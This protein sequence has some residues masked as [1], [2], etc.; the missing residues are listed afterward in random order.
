MKKKTF[1]LLFFMLLFLTGIGSQIK[2]Q[3][4]FTDL[5]IAVSP[6]ME[7]AKY[8]NV[9][10]TV[11]GTVSGDVTFTGLAA[12]DY[13]VSMTLGVAKG[14]PNIG[15]SDLAIS[16]VV[17]TIDAS[18]NLTG[19]SGDGAT[20]SGT[21][22]EVP[23]RFVVARPGQIS[24][25]IWNLGV[26]LMTSPDE[27]T[28]NGVLNPG[29][30]GLGAQD[31]G[32]FPIVF[33]PQELT[34]TG[35]PSQS[36]CSGNSTSRLRI[37]N[38]RPEA[39]IDYT[40][41]V[42][43]PNEILS[44]GN[45]PSWTGYGNE[46]PSLTITHK[47]LTELP[48]SATVTLHA[49]K[50]YG[51]GKTCELDLDVATF[52]VNPVAKITNTA[53]IQNDLIFCPGTK[54]TQVNFEVFGATEVKITIANAIEA[55]L[56]GNPFRLNDPSG[57]IAI[58]AD[59]LACK[60][61][62]ISVGDD[63]IAVGTLFEKYLAAPR[64]YNLVATPIYKNSDGRSCEG[65]KLSF[66][67]VVPKV[68]DPIYMY[69]T[70]NLLEDIFDEDN[71]LNLS[72]VNQIKP[73]ESIVLCPGALTTLGFHKMNIV[74]TIDAVKYLYELMQ[75]NNGLLEDFVK[76]VVENYETILPMFEGDVDLL[77]VLDLIV[78]AAGSGNYQ[79]ISDALTWDVILQLGLKLP[80]MIPSLVG[81]LDGVEVTIPENN[82]GLESMTDKEYTNDFNVIPFLAKFNVASS[83]PQR[84]TV[85]ARPYMYIRG[86]K[87]Y[88]TTFSYDII[89]NPTPTI[90]AI[91]NELMV[92]PPDRNPDTDGSYPIEIISSG[93]TGLDIYADKDDKGIIKNGLGFPGGKTTIDLVVGTVEIG[94]GI[95]AEISLVE[96]GVYKTLITIPEENLDPLTLSA[97]FVRPTGSCEIGIPS[98]FGVVIPYEMP[99]LHFD[100]VDKVLRY[101]NGDMVN[102]IWLTPYRNGDSPWEVS[103]VRLESSDKVSGPTDTRDS[104]TNIIPRFWA[105]NETD[106]V[107]R[108]EFKYHVKSVL[109]G[110][111]F[112]S[113]GSLIIEVEPYVVEDTRIMINEI[114]DITVC[115][116]DEFADIVFEARYEFPD[117]TDTIKSPITFDEIKFE[118]K[119]FE[120]EDVLG[121]GI[122][123]T[124]VSD[125][126]ETSV[127]FVTAGTTPAKS[128][129]AVYG[130]T[131]RWA[132]GAGKTMYFNIAVGEKPEITYLRT[133]KDAAGTTAETAP[134]YNIGDAI[135]I[136]T[137][138]AALYEWVNKGVNIGLANGKGSSIPTFIASKA[139][140][141]EIEVTPISTVACEGEAKTFFI[142]VNAAPSFGDFTIM[143][144][145]TYCSGDDVE[146]ALPKLAPNTEYQLSYV[147]GVDLG[148]RIRARQG[149]STI[150]E[151]RYEN[152]T[153][154]PT[155]ATYNLV[156]VDT[157][158]GAQSEVITFVVTITPNASIGRI[159]NIEAS[160]GTVIP[161]FTFTGN[162][163]TGSYSW[164][165]KRNS[166]K[167]DN[168]ASRGEGSTFP[169]FTAVNLGTR[170]VTATYVV[171]ATSGECST[172]T[173]EFSIIVY[174]EASIPVTLED[175]VISPCKVSGVYT[176]AT[177]RADNNYIYELSL[178]AGEEVG[179]SIEKRQGQWRI[180]GRLTNATD[181][182][183]TA[184]Y[185]LTAVN[186]ETGVKGASEEFTIV[187]LPEP[188][189]NRPNNIAAIHGTEI[190]AFTFTGNVV[191]GTYSWELRGGRDSDK[192]PN[193]ATRGEGSFFP[194]FV[195]ENF[196]NE[197]I[198]A[199]YDV[200]AQSGE[201]TETT[202]FRITVY[203][204]PSIEGIENFVGCGSF[205]G[206]AITR[207]EDNVR[208]DL[209]FV[210]G[211]DFDLEL[212]RRNNRWSVANNNPSNPFKNTGATILIGTYKVTPYNTVT[213]ATGE[214]SY[215]NVT[216]YP[217]PAV[218]KP[219]D[220]LVVNGT[221]VPS[222]AF[223]GEVE[224]SSYK[225]TLKDGSESIPNLAAD[226]RGSAFPAFVAENFTDEA[227]IA[228]YV[229]TPFN[230]YCDGT[231]VE[232]TITV[233]P[234][235]LVPEILDEIFC[236]NHEYEYI[237]QGVYDNTEFTID[238]VSGH[239]FD[240]TI[241]L[242]EEQGWTITVAG[243]E[244][245]LV[246][247]RNVTVTGTYRVTAIN[248]ITAA[249]GDTEEFTITV[250][251]DA[252][253]NTV[254]NISVI[255]GTSVPAFTFTGNAKD[256][257]Y[258]WALKEGSIK[259][260]NLASQG[261][262][263][264][265]PSFV[266]ENFTAGTIA[267]TYVVTATSGEGCTPATKEFTITIY[268]APSIAGIN[269]VVACAQF[270]GFELPAPAA[271]DE[272]VLEFVSGTN[273]SLTLVDGVKVT[274]TY[275]NTTSK[276]VSAIYKVTPRHKETLA[277]GAPN[278]FTI[279]LNPVPTM[280]EPN[281]IRVVTGTSVPEFAFKGNVAGMTYE[282]TLKAES[283]S[284]PNLSTIGEGL[285]FPAFVAEN[286]TDETIVATYVV[287][288]VFEGCEGTPVEFTIT[289][290]PGPQVQEIYDQT[291]CNGSEY[292]KVLD[293]MENVRYE[294][295]YVKGA[296]LGLVLEGREISGS[297]V[298]DTKAPIS[299]TYRITA[300][301][302]ITGAPGDT[303]E[304]TITVLPDLKNEH[305]VISN[306][307]Y[308]NGQ[309]VNDIFF[310]SLIEGARY[311]WKYVSGDKIGT[312]DEGV[313]F[314]SAFVANNT[315]NRTLVATYEVTM[316][317]EGCTSEAKLFTITVYPNN[318]NM[319]N[320]LDVVATVNGVVSLN[321]TVCYDEAF[322][323]IT[324]TA[325]HAFESD[326]IAKG[327]VTF[328]VVL[329][330]GTDIFG[331]VNY[332][333]SED[334][335]IATVSASA[336]PQ[337]EG[338][339]KYEVIA[340]WKNNYSK[341]I[342]ITLT[343]KAAP[344]VNVIADKVYCNNSPLSVDFTGNT[345]D[346]TYTWKVVDAEGNPTA[347]KLG[348]PAGAENARGLS[349]AKLTNNTDGVL[350]DI[351]VVTPSAGGCT[352]EAVVFTISVIPT[353]TVG[354]IAT[355]FVENGANVDAIP[356]T[357][358][359]T[360][361]EWYSSNPTINNDPSAPASGSGSEFPAF[362]AQNVV[363][364]PIISV[365][366]V[367]PVY[368]YNGYTCSGSAMTF[369]IIVAP[370]PAITG[371]ADVIVCDGE[372]V[373]P[374]TPNG[375]PQGYGYYI[376]WTG[377]TSIGLA[378]STGYQKNISGF[379][380][381]LPADADKNNA[382]IVP[383]TV[384][385]K[386]QINGRDY[387]G[388]PVIFNYIVLP[389]AILDANAEAAVA[390]NVE[391]CEGED[392]ELTVTA[393]GYEISYQW[394]KNAIVIPGATE[395]VYSI[396]DA[397]AAASGEYYVVVTTGGS[398]C[399]N[400]VQGQ[401]YTVLVKQDVISQ[402]WNDVL[403]LD[404]DPVTN[405]GHTFT[406]IQWYKNGSVIQGENLTYLYVEAGLDF[407]ATY[408]FI[409][410][411][412][413]GTFKS[414]DFT[415]ARQDATSI[416][417]APNP[418]KA[419][420]AV[421]LKGAGSARAIQ[422][423]SAM[424]AVVDNIRPNGNE[425]AITMPN[426]T[427]V[428]ILRVIIDDN[429][430]ES[431]SII[432]K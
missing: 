297:L 367:I 75:T 323:D 413:N 124:L 426:T 16:D 355:Q 322:K 329:S 324:L 273:M 141:A 284:I 143:D 296:D 245:K 173:R 88:G 414:C 354:V 160:H 392:I 165:L 415:P 186:A 152:E 302:T 250:R 63:G 47:G 148:L 335:N 208:Y 268:P 23:V 375:L 269:D 28:I 55:A 244:G 339:A 97:Y 215:F 343:R 12:G 390:R 333:A 364:S 389:N 310:T 34:I 379:V 212:S 262:G 65:T 416:T 25:G 405:G 54:E 204:A 395:S 393:T 10:T 136:Q 251:P 9:V 340:Y 64:T 229:V 226:G 138:G 377:G 163:G 195:A 357:G 252:K 59:V 307:E 5:E 260:P 51:N 11:S 69:S 429:K 6:N 169:Q 193:L 337:V 140:I 147:E 291:F 383:V 127:V 66:S 90:S 319:E 185:M 67:V 149:Q 79:A 33:R 41:V 378:N 334:S 345:A 125:A 58:A 2:A 71:K 210:S 410:K 189:I 237:L 332:Y 294:M 101:K 133:A 194:S 326:S 92:C 261:E 13:P 425:M 233:H 183:V 188:N 418:V 200:T 114:A 279:T 166:D 202:S 372:Y 170:P 350:T 427:G 74:G 257:S 150:V 17:F 380:A 412:A 397:K 387:E 338:T 328:K 126:G 50:S 327:P 61:T 351:I 131:P 299:G 285:T 1:R 154:A 94:N 248:T 315:T 110:C 115:D 402:R 161:A 196:T 422:L 105:V 246:N 417:V 164:Q 228:T 134:V 62:T 122:E 40:W 146:I 112:Y 295:S 232:F 239:N 24:E 288:P 109:T 292:S 306:K 298:N 366:T 356:F 408:Y 388:T 3:I 424:G 317:I 321:Q 386:V 68:G 187:V 275:K 238:Y 184:T 181:A 207:P 83:V 32:E 289:V 132:N 145:T 290:Y 137:E 222:F 243:E 42:D 247:D 428:Y 258:A 241:D 361:F 118:W 72:L 190:P 171:T 431:F 374:F 309:Q 44:G 231:P 254:D 344:V 227:I 353:P 382:T 45:G 121:K 220:I 304:F 430:V 78:K 46:F 8:L 318:L 53:Y 376:S 151:G 270:V 213:L 300:I 168:L 179:L 82:I 301:N 293:E 404:A 371:I 272:Y 308:Y 182:P 373:E 399:S 223:V 253:V 95:T 107:L 73:G 214:P 432:V 27:L 89:V 369:S 271:T 104:G 199:I 218:D 235:P 192:L 312:A 119:L 276:V 216:L 38:N 385:P 381:K 93:A 403:V 330:E 278:Y 341:S 98:L 162:V 18:G 139:G 30:S 29:G 206:L 398:E 221:S 265:F 370:R 22:F 286:F 205:D 120:G 394:Y 35:K 36:Y 175:V 108:A 19:I 76:F 14:Q 91:N 128:G 157:E 191:G 153:N 87:C 421:I 172:A 287:T 20:Y 39:G 102:D 219:A 99:D 347:S 116:G 209:E 240:L 266:A 313:D 311:S 346:G 331:L 77:K 358:T 56:Y 217:A 57:F 283:A 368:E 267:A 384:V 7:C 84:V 234:A 303:E 281:S 129:K 49:S 362:T 15:I 282:W 21:T 37:N 155:T 255:H 159:D 305:I 365:I 111:S 70:G 277:V 274:G 197:P 401:T 130:V 176:Y 349:A 363:E 86:E 396:K 263:P 198:V 4:N 113:E 420:Q 407:N 106:R 249:A 142:K 406:D 256:G 391:F 360:T 225:W 411:T 103:W 211:T 352:G 236:N 336:A 81:N 280:I 320:N 348:L 201:C 359:A 26:T 80:S 60:P 400:S 135:Q 423:V 314:I 259:L 177:F 325:K 409:A 264:V 100:L 203:P 174:P 144:L 96:E 230:L 342:Y 180:S 158:T 178:V 224:G 242:V 167:I 156:I 52:T 117:L 419:G 85:S 31:L 48:Q 43:D 123:A 316:T